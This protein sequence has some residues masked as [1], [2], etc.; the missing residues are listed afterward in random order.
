MNRY[1]G[2]ETNRFL[3]DAMHWGEEI[4][5]LETQFASITEI[6]GISAEMPSGGGEISRPTESVALSKY[7]IKEKIDRIKKYRGCFVYAWKRIEDRDRELLRGFYFESGFIYKFVDEWCKE[8]ASNR[9][10]CYKAKREAEERFGAACI[11]WME[12]NGYDV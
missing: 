8:Y 9:D 5:R 1:F 2:F 10:Y 12:L 3:K 11:E 6:G 4:E 7:E